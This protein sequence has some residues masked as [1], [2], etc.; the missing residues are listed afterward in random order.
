[1]RKASDLNKGS[2]ESGRG[3]RPGPLPS[4]RVSDL[5][6]A[7]RIAF[8]AD[9][10]CLV[11]LSVRTNQHKVVFLNG[12]SDRVVYDHIGWVV[13]E[14]QILDVFGPVS[15]IA[16]PDSQHVDHLG[17]LYRVAVSVDLSVLLFVVAVAYFFGRGGDSGIKADQPADLPIRVLR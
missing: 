11:F 1:M 6:C 5:I 8:D 4:V 2:S 9:D 10:C 15:H 7:L 14:D 12:N 16:N 17:L 13:A 3:F